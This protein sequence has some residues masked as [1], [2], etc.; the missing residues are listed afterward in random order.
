MLLYVQIKMTIISWRTHTT[1]SHAVPEENSSPRNPCK[2]PLVLPHTSTKS[3]VIEKILSVS[4]VVRG[5]LWAVHVLALNRAP[6]GAWA[7]S[8][9]TQTPPSTPLRTSLSVLRGNRIWLQTGTDPVLLLGDFYGMLTSARSA[10]SWASVCSVYSFHDSQ[11]WLLERWFNHIT[12]LPPIPSPLKI[13]AQLHVL[14][15]MLD[16]WLDLSVFAENRQ[17]SLGHCGEDT[18]S[19]STYPADPQRYMQEGFSVPRQLPVT[20]QLWNQTH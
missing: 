11:R 19:W 1:P 9:S 17:C 3:K 6:P 15:E 5:S 18:Y 4:V 10:G 12:A 20:F 16:K 13:Q 14:V 2:L 7:V 8:S